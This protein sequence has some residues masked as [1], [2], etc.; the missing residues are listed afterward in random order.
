[1]CKK[2]YLYFT[3]AFNLITESEF[4]YYLAHFTDKNY[5]LY[6]LNLYHASLKYVVEAM[7][8]Q[9]FIIRL[10]Y[11]KRHKKLPVVLSQVEIGL[12]LASCKNYIHKLLL[13]LAYG[14]G[15]RLSEVVSLKVQDLDFEELTLHIKQAK[16]QKDRITIIPESLIDSLKTIIV[17]IKRDDF[18]FA[19]GQG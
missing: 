14:A 4:K 13:S 5:S 16:G 8:H 15:L 1:M 12:F 2:I 10:P 11:A 6:T 19:S 17:G 9:P 7:Y 3:K 18:V